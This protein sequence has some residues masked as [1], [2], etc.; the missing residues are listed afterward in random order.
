VWEPLKGEVSY[1]IMIVILFPQLVITE[2][3]NTTV[4]FPEKPVVRPP[5]M[6]LLE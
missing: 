4:P 3:S 2:I 6:K 1:L 5:K